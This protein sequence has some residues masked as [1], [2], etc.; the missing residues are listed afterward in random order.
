VLGDEQFE[1]DE[2]WP[3]RGGQPPENPAA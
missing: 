1:M 2:S 3:P